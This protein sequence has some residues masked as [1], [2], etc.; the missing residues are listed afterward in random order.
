MEADIA[1]VFL[2]FDMEIK[3]LKAIDCLESSPIK[4]LILDPIYI[5][6]PVLQTNKTITNE[7]NQHYSGI[8][9][10][11]LSNQNP[12][13]S[14]IEGP[15]G[16]G[17]TSIIVNSVL[18][19]FEDQQPEKKSSILICSKDQNRLDNILRQI[20]ARSK[21]PS[22]SAVI[23][24]NDQQI[25]PK[26]QSFSINSLVQKEF[27]KIKNLS[28]TKVSKALTLV[29]SL[30]WNLMANIFSQESESQI[31]NEFERIRKDLEM[32]KLL[33]ER[34]RLKT[35]IIDKA[36]LVCSSLLTCSTLHK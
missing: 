34:Q 13:I 2:N 19:I 10:Q 28:A 20:I 17:K 27:D 26:L 12:S 33:L 35:E 5:C 18:K 30:N 3:K 6:R 25:Q 14:M 9:L 15:I 4:H 29:L 1:I 7:H 31:A 8:S 36:E 24:A 11:I 32:K 16:S 23:W 22:L 21:N